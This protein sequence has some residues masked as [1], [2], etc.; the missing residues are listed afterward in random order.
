MR[1]LQVHVGGK[2]VGHL[3]EEG[4]SG[5]FTYLPD[6]D[7]DL[8]VSLRMPVR[9][10][11]WT[12]P[13][14]VHPIFQMNLPEG[15]R[16]E[17]LRIAVGPHADP[18]DMGLLELTGATGIGRVQVVPDGVALADAQNTE[19]MAS[20]LAAPDS[21]ESLLALLQSS[22]MQGVSGVMPKAFASEGRPRLLEHEK[23]TA[24]TP[25]YI[26]KTG[27]E[28]L[29]W[30]S[31]N[32][33]LCLE[34]ARHAGLDVPVT[35]LSDDGQVLAVK[36]FDRAPD[37]TMIALEDFCALTGRVPTDKYKGSLEQFPEIVKDLV[38]PAQR[39]E[40]MARLF[41]LHLINY[42]LRNGD[43]HLKNFAL[44]YTGTQDVRLAPVFDIVTVTV[45]PR[46]RRDTP[47][48]TLR[49]KKVWTCGKTL[50][51][52]AGAIMGLNAAVRTACVE[53]VTRAVQ[54]VL[55][56]LMEMAARFP[57]FREMAKLMADEW[58]KGLEDIRPDAK[59]G[60]TRPAPLREQVGL[61]GYKG[62][63]KKEVSPYINP[64]GPFSHK[65]R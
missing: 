37:G 42:A 38:P 15:Y 34:V 32:E 21:R 13:R 31:V 4:A 30:I 39:A 2:L 14:G 62:T 23:L 61:S 24:Q 26:L 16:K 28:D 65:S 64:D 46:L 48:L 29:P 59:P 19:D 18:S 50:Q 36:R 60:K 49:G 44:L 12:F 5:V 41:T 52:H 53:R 33:Y 57:G 7:P 9:A 51:E 1:R 10:M 35:S 47:A 63:A 8:L 22:V 11:S 40:T 6:V 3:A 25:D 54:Q 17:L 27:S 55:P 20:V 43:A 56:V 45:Y 58:A